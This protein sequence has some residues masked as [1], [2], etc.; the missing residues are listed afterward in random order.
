ME[1]SVNITVGYD[2]VNY[3]KAL[4]DHDLLSKPIIK[5]IPSEIL[6]SN[7][8]EAINSIIE[9]IDDGV[10]KSDLFEM[11]TIEFTFTIDAEGQISLL[12]LANGSISTGA[13][14]TITLARKGKGL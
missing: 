10:I 6:K 2:Q 13:G 12:S 1:K 8:S 5:A 7:L 3:G 9:V 11:D 14:I 4:F